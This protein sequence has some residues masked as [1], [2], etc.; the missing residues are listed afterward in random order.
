VL[1]EMNSMYGVPFVIPSSREAVLVVVADRR[2]FDALGRPTL[3]AITVPLLRPMPIRKP[4]SWP[5]SR[6]PVVEAA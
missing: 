2:V 5:C 6:S 3:P 4:D 1:S